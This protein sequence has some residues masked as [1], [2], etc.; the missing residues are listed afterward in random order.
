MP[1]CYVCST[2]GQ[3]VA[4]E[5]GKI[6]TTPHSLNHMVV[7]NHTNAVIFSPVVTVGTIVTVAMLSTY[8]IVCGTVQVKTVPYVFEIDKGIQMAVLTC[9][10]AAT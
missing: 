6:T 7:K 9:E 10:S 3:C 5:V 8:S 4:V 2:L 1:A